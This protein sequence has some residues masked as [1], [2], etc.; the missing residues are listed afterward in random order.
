M[1]WPKQQ[2]DGIPR[3]EQKAVV[4]RGTDTGAHPM[5][6]F[7]SS[8]FVMHHFVGKQEHWLAAC[9]GYF[10]SLGVGDDGVQDCPLFYSAEGHP[11]VVLPGCLQS[12]IETDLRTH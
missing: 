8:L 7:E 12:V 9:S 3:F 10:R 1:A 4:Q 5:A 2:V 6:G 11:L